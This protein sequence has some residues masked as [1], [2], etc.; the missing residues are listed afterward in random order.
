MVITIVQIPRSGPKPDKAT[1]IEG[2]KKSA[3]LYCEVKGLIRKDFLN[4]EECG[5]GVYLWESREAAEAWFND[6]WWGWIEDRFGAR[7]TLTYFDHYLTVDNKSG[8]IRVDDEPIAIAEQ[9]AE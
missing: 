6:E 3:P 8:D 7:P 4:G 1:S 2:A 5:G 9:A